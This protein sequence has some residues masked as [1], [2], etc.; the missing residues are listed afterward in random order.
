MKLAEA[1]GLRSDA[2]KRLEQLS[3]RA[4]AVARYQEGEPPAEDPAVLVEQARATVDEIE[5]LVRRIN[6]TNAATELQAGQTI[7]D[8][9]ARRDALKARRKLE[10]DIADA[11]TGRDRGL[12]FMRSTRSELRYVTDLSV[13]DLRGQADRVARELRELDT[14]IQQANWNTELVE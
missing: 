9:I 14:L 2:Q 12:G 8:A 10:A 3:A 7:T 1:L 6:R 5:G 11:A 4:S 13:T